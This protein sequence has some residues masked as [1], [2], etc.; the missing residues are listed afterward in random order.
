MELSGWV[1]ALRLKF[2]TATFVPV[3]LSFSL[4][5]WQGY[6]TSLLL[7]LISFLSIGAI[8]VGANLSNDYFDHLSGNDE[9]N[10][11][12][13]HFSGGSRAIQKGILTPKQVL[14]SAIGFY[15]FGLVGG[16]AT[17]IY[18][19]IPDIAGLYVLGVL[20]AYYYC[21]PPAKLAY[22]GYAEASNFV[23][24]G[25]LITVTAYITQTG[26]FNAQTLLSSFIP[27][28]HLAL[29]LLINE[30]PDYKAD[31]EAGKK[32]MV[33]R[34]GPKTAVCLF[35][36]GLQF[37]YI[38]LAL[39]VLLKVLPIL[40]IFGIVTLPLAYRIKENSGK[41]YLNPPLLESSN[42]GMILLH[43]SFGTII[44]ASLLV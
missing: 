14:K 32:T 33:V 22:R 20:L 34:Y 4:A 15:M 29:V 27:G 6:D 19:N 28:L 44:A 26:A 42:K 7:G 36:I 2:L 8:Q 30:F 43:L 17:A 21:A 40:S 24:F 41:H 35:H 13:S 31:K 12:G 37:V 1:S 18:L 23:A 38:Y 16:V 39:L 11:S 5:Q 10:T 9:K 25:P 3:T